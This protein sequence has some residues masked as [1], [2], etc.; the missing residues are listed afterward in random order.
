MKILT[1]GNGFVSKHLKY[2][3]YTDR[4]HPNYKSVADFIDQA[5]P[6]VIINCIGFTGGNGKN[7]DG[8]EEEKQKTFDTNT[9]LPIML[10]TVCEK[11]DVRLIHIGSGCVFYGT[12]PH[13]N[14][15][16]Q[17]KFNEQYKDYGWLENDAA[18]PLSTYSKSKYAADIAL[19]TMKTT[20]NLRIRM[21]LSWKR[22]PR[23]LIT[24][25]IDYKKVVE[26]PNSMTLM[27]DLS[28]S[29][30][31]AIDRGKVGTYHITSPEPLTHSEILREYQKYRPAHIFESISPAHLDKLVSAPRSNCI[32]DSSKATREGF[33]FLNVRETIKEYV[34]RYVEEGNESER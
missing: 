27:E 21:P 11:R 31:W 2:P 1:I 33:T 10:A 26:A 9:L 24:K 20:T 4:L 5:M 32:L 30:E 34:R 17:H 6:D 7:I 15:I 23:N 3:I 18:L 28:R 13:T 12:S 16:S 19:Q 14:V 22:E 29:V 8:C 25:L